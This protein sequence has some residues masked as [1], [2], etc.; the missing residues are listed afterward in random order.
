MTS[1]SRL[2]VHSKEKRQA[3]VRGEIHKSGTKS[4]G[5]SF[6]FVPLFAPLMTIAIELA[7]PVSLVF[8]FLLKNLKRNA[9]RG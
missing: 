3:R 7:V 5:L 6:R 1:N 4:Y 8:L 2:L 9:A